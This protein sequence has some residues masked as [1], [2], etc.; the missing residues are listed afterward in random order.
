[1]N[2]WGLV[3]ALAV[4]ALAML[5]YGLTLAPDITFAHH[6]T[7][8]G[9]LI[10]AAAT[11]GI[12]HPTGYPTY[13]ALA[14]LFTRIPLGT[15][16][17]RVHL[18][19]AV[20]MAVASGLLCL[21]IQR[22]LSHAECHIGLSVAAALSFALAPL[23]WSQAIIAEVYAL[24]ALF[25]V[26]LLWLL[27]RW[28]AGSDNRLLPLAALVLGL[29]LGNHIT[30]TFALPGMVFWFWPHHN[31]LKSRTHIALSLVLFLTGLAI[32]GYLPWAARRQPPVNWG[33]PQTWKQFLWVVTAKQYQSF[34]FTL[35]LSETAPRIAT[36]A[37]L[38]GRQLGWWGLAISLLGGWS[39]WQR[40]WSLASFTGTWILVTAFYSFWYHT[41][42]SHIYMIVPLLFQCLWWGEGCRFLLTT[43][44]LSRSSTAWKKGLLALLLILPLFS[45]ARNWSDID[46]SHDRSVPEYV[47]NVLETVTPDSVVIVR[48]DRPTFSLWYA[49]FAQR[50]R[51]DIAVVSGP[52]L[53][54]TWYRHQIRSQYPHLLVPEPSQRKVTIDDVVVS[55]VTANLSHHPV[56]ATDPSD[57]WT[58]TLKFE[59]QGQ[60][61]VYRVHP[62]P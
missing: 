1:M 42:D 45:L 37:A 5:V 11:L 18:L 14:W 47:H 54:Y 10:A 31:R 4:T 44:N 6:G 59:A 32:Y 51:E 62:R 17:F 55:F 28:R 19:S 26:A 48:G 30:L 25:A 22:L 13:V 21:T 12:P 36:W 23:A 15:I 38:A 33:N 49:I 50:Q 39:C 8:G 16:A 27:V 53:A 46:L 61:P 56:W 40:D 29:G 43:L 35:P 3:A 7:D 34:A 60:A 9:D 57:Q 24:H 2:R 52:L 20:S 58:T 41:T